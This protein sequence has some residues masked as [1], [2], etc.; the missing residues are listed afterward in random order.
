MALLG[1][2]ISLASLLAIGGEVVNRLRFR[3]EALAELPEEK[4]SQ[5]K[6][7]PRARAMQRTTG[8]VK[9]LSNF[10]YRAMQVGVLLIAA[11]WMASQPARHWIV[12][13]TAVVF[14]FAA[15]CNA[16]ALQAKSRSRAT[17]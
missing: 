10:I 2:T 12:A 15:A 9:P 7:D 6:L 14:S 4:H 13:T 17:C 8:I 3:P 16:W 11:P 1:E 5:V